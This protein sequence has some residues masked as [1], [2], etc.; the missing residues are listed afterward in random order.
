MNRVYLCTPLVLVLLAAAWARAADNNSKSPLDADTIKVALH[1]ATPE[2]NGFIEYVLG[3][4]D[5]GTL[6]LDLVESTFLWARKKPHR[7]FQ[8]FKLGLIQRAADLGIKL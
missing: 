2:E 7:K 4:V 5:K 8:Y 1:T 3:R 6:P